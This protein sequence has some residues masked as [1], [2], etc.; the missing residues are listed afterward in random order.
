M[1]NGSGQDF[2]IG[3]NIFSMR[4]TVV[5]YF[6]KELIWLNLALSIADH[7]TLSALCAVPDEQQMWHFIS[8]FHRA[9]ISSYMIIPARIIFAFCLHLWTN[10]RYLLM[11]FCASIT[12]I[13]VR[14]N[15]SEADS[16]EIFHVFYASCD[17]SGVLCDYK[18]TEPFPCVRIR[19]W[20][21]FMKAL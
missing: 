20:F 18:T 6:L 3:F 15:F 1:W 21:Q 16:Q 8:W 14:F 17:E 19:S 7:F 2:S 4:V 10:K 9:M 13:G 12:H 5:I 11:V